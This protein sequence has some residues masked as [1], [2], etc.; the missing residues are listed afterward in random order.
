VFILQV[1]IDATGG[2]KKVDLI[3]AL[4]YGCDESVRAVFQLSTFAPAS[5]GGELVRPRI[6]RLLKLEY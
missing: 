4:G 1:D 5:A 3:Q 6:P 2:V